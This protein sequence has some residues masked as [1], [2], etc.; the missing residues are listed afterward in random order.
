MDLYSFI[1]SFVTLRDERSTSASKIALILFSII[2]I[3]LAV[4]RSLVLFNVVDLKTIYQLDWLTNTL[5]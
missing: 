4:T 3:V 2:M 1:C 5:N